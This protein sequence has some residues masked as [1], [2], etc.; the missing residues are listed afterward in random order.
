MFGV[1]LLAAITMSS[2]AFGQATAPPVP[3]PIASD[4]DGGRV[5]GGSPA[6]PGTAPWQVELYSTYRYTPQDFAEDDAR[7]AADPKKRFFSLR[8][9]WELGHRC[10]GAWLGDNWI[11]TAAHCV[12]EVTGNFLE[13]RRV[14]LG[15]QDLSV[16]GTTYA[17]ESAVVHMGYVD[18]E[19]YP[20]DIALIRIAPGDPIPPSV[21]PIRILG[22]AAGDRPLA[23]GDALRVTGWGLTQPR[24]SGARDAATNR[25]SP[26]LLQ[27]ALSA[28]PDA[29]CDAVPDYAKRLPGKTVCGGSTIPGRD[30]CSGDSGGPLT[31]AQGSERVLVGIVS[32]GRG[33]A[34]AG[35]PGI[36]TRASD[37]RQWI[38]GAKTAARPGQ[39]SRY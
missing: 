6:A 7:G 22:D 28:F 39:V 35:Y 33:C 30:A 38:A 17:I 21:K 20:N 29:R 1:A 27:V 34:L 13:V 16:G 2:A 9:G 14:R 32:W 11:L 37:Y 31:R 10:G 26:V 8:Q 25:Q 23:S 15:T 19:P 12:I 5:V 24:V 18:G 3:P 4:D 36:Y